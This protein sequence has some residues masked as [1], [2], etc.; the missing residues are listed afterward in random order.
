[1]QQTDN[2]FKLPQLFYQ[3]GSFIWNVMKIEYI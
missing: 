2:A 3:K 1:M